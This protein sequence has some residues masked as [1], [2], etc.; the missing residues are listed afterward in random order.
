MKKRIVSIMALSLVV[1]M[2]A[3]SLTGCGT[4]TKATDITIEDGDAI[5]V[6]EEDMETEAKTEAESE[7]DADEITSTE[8]IGGDETVSDFTGAENESIVLYAE[9][10]EQRKYLDIYDFDYLENI[11]TLSAAS[12]IPVYDGAGFNVGHIKNGSTVEVEEMAE[13]I[14]WSRFKNPIEGTEYDYLYVMNDNFVVSN[15]ITV[16]RTDIVER[17]TYNMNNRAYELPTILETPTSDMEVYEFRIPATYTNEVDFKD[18][19][20]FYS[21][22]NGFS[23]G[24][25]MTYAIETIEDGGDII[26]KIFYKDLYEDWVENQ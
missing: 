18:D 5:I 14:A 19:I 15:Q 25:Y 20:Y 6:D 17:L 7:S 12:D 26:C 4:R 2:G 16:S 23:V 3:V 22:D 11:R 13:G 21:Y 8:V 24:S 1:T 10:E 9:K